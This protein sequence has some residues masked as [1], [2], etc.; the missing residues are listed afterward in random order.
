MKS[1][2]NIAEA[3]RRGYKIEIGPP[4]SM[5]GLTASEG[6]ECCLVIR[7]GEVT[8]GTSYDDLDAK[9]IQYSLEQLDS[10]WREKADT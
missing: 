5:V 4:E 2:E 10:I 1:F 9:K 7:R 8:F 6:V 3:V